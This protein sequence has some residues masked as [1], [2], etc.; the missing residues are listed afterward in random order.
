MK[1]DFID[2]HAREQLSALLDGELDGD[3]ARFLQRR[4][5]HDDALVGQLVRWQLAG[6][7][8]RAHA[9][10][11]HEHEEEDLAGRV[12]AAI[13][14]EQSQAVSKKPRRGWMLWGSGLAAAAAFGFAALNLPATV[15]PAPPA[16]TKVAATMPATQ[17]AVAPLA[18]APITVAVAPK[19]SP[20]DA[21]VEPVAH[22]VAETAPHHRQREEVANVPRHVQR[23]VQE[24]A[25]VP[26]QREVAVAASAAPAKAKTKLDRNP[27]SMPS[28]A[29]QSEL[30]WPKATLPGFNSG[31]N[32]DFRSDSASGNPFM[33]HRATFESSPQH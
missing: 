12:R 7:V 27:F 9:R 24:E 18:A 15:D 28:A 8:L 11:P 26:Q 6:D 22:R 13:E 10:A 5:E 21:V 16:P 4:L 31:L 3:A 2:T 17:R 23:D 20:A 1:H 33:P 25:P 29:A 30:P 14:R 19:S 32:A